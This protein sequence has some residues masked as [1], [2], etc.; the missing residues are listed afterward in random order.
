[1]PETTRGPWTLRT[2]ATIYENP[3]I[4]VT[5]HEVLRPDGQPGVYGVV[6]F[7]NL[8]IAI[9]PL[10]DD[11][12]TWLVGQHRFPLDLF[13]WEVPEGGGSLGSDPLA[14]AQRELKEETGIVA[15]RWDEI[16]RMH[17]SNSVSD[18]S[19]VGFVARGLRFEA[20]EPEGSEQLT[21]RKVP[22]SEV[23][24]MVMRGE[25]SDALSVATV[26]KAHALQL[27]ECRAKG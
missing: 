5:H 12:N 9:L 16:L 27:P 8:A 24:A 3:W 17:M 15:E 22:F 7:K 19:A 6:H 26:L 11:G 21:V 10:D 2:S 4:G 14:A 13:S 23:F 20:A 25:I 1:M 18:E